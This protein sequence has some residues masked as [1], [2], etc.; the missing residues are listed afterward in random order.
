MRIF[1]ASI[2]VIF[3]FSACA[4]PW[5]DKTALEVEPIAASD[6]ESRAT[7]H[8]VVITDGS[9]TMTQEANFPEARA[10]AQSFI[11]AMPEA[12]DNTYRAGLINFGGDD[13]DTAPLADFDRAALADQA[14]WISP[15]GVPGNATTPLDDVLGEV[16]DELAGSQGRAAIVIFSD[17][18]P[19]SEEH[20][21]AAARSLIASHNGEVCIHTV[22]SGMDQA[23]QAFLKELSELTG[24][25][26]TRSGASLST[27]SDMQGFERDIFMVSMAA[28]PAVGA[29]GPCTRKVVLRG[30]N[31]GFDQAQITSESSTILDAAADH[32]RRCGKVSIQV[33]GFT[34]TIGTEG[35]NE[36]LSERRATAVRDY[37][38]DTGVSRSQLTA[39]GYGESNPVASNETA[40]GRAQ[41]RRVELTPQ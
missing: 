25:G 35:Y 27:S 34:D 14:A 5:P 4:K 20:S 38:I 10:L 19:N 23:G 32:L 30:I 8:I 37:L 33:D 40:D 2:A 39:K 6:Q 29:I 13:R 28:P 16:Q 21:L 1:A 18:L 11:A 36:G 24:C 41:N 15:L 7:D 9:A 12:D 31:F 26:S 17:G 3:M 22:H